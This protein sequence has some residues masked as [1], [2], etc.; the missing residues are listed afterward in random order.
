MPRPIK[1]TAGEVATMAQLAG[2]SPALAVTAWQQGALG[3]SV[4]EVQE[5][6]G[7][8]RSAEFED[9]M[10]EPTGM[11]D[12]QQLGSEDNIP[13]FGGQAMTPMQSSYDTF[14][15]QLNQI[16]SNNYDFDRYIRNL[17]E[18]EFNNV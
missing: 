6:L 7:S 17:V 12:P 10:P 11:L 13:R 3:Q 2:V 9:E 14:D 18:E 1:L 4:D 15:P 5:K 8:M 16:G